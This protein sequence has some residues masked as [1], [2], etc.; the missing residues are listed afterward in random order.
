MRQHAVFHPM[1]PPRMLTHGG[2]VA[3][4]ALGSPY[5][6][7]RSNSSV[8]LAI[9]TGCPYTELVKIFTTA[10]YERNAKRLLKSDE[11][12]AMEQA[13]TAGPGKH[14]VIQGTGGVRKA[15]WVRQ[16]SGKSGGVRVIYYHMVV[17]SEIH[18]LFIYAK[19]D[20]ADLTAE[21]RK[22]VKKY[23]EGL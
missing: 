17:G 23:V 20:Q 22:I 15:R 2:S 1:E 8:P 11:Q 10:N 7:I 13:I 21:Q 19:K 12:T 5:V 14:P 6:R 18:F 3:A 4:C 16:G 9:Y